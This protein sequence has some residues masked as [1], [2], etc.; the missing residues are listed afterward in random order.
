VI[1]TAPFVFILVTNGLVVQGA[2]VLT[3]LM[4]LAACPL[5]IIQQMLC[6][7]LMAL[8]GT[9][10]WMKR[11]RY[12][13]RGTAF[14][15]A[16]VAATGTAV[17]GYQVWLQRNPWADGCSVGL[18][19]WEEFVA[20]AGERMHIFKAEGACSDFGLQF[21]GISLAQWSLGFF[22]ISLLVSLL[23]LLRWYREVE[24]G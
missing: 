3:Q 6:L 23:A 15:L 20:W 1:R 5:C 14:A 2:L 8:A 11:F 17:S 16:L 19:W 12:G 13:F 7:L 24:W 18:K 21:A 22:L 9:G 10:L 4:H